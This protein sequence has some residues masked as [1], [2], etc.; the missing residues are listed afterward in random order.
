MLK[1]PSDVVF[2]VNESARHC[3]LAARGPIE[4]QT[5]VPKNAAM[6]PVPLSLTVICQAINDGLRVKSAA[7]HRKLAR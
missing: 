1:A 7:V 6:V 3:A 2:V 4:L 5:P